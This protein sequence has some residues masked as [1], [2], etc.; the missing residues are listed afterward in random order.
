M[1]GGDGLGQGV[2]IVGFGYGLIGD[3]THRI[4]GGK[5]EPKLL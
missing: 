4:A 1:T 2:K 5:N 3:R